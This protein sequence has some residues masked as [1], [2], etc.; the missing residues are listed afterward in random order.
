MFVAITSSALAVRPDVD[1]EIS[2]R[3]V[4]APV[5]APYTA[6]G[7]ASMKVRVFNL[8]ESVGQSAFGVTV[9]VR[10]IVAA[11]SFLSPTSPGC[12]RGRNGTFVCT[13]FS[14][15]GQMA[16]FREFR[17]RLRQGACSLLTPNNQVKVARANVASNNQTHDPN[18]ENNLTFVYV[19]VSCPAVN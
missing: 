15:D 14:V 3:P 18:V 16:K 6:G 5:G 2:D 9:V 10:P 8:N 11:I 17:V 19:N 13:L 7:I 4:A 12:V 1:L